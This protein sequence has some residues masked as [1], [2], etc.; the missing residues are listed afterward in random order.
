MAMRRQIEDSAKCKKTE[1]DKYRMKHLYS[2][3]VRIL[4]M[5]DGC[6]AFE[7]KDLLNKIEQLKERHVEEQIDLDSDPDFIYYGTLIKLF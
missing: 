7:L 6:T 3:Q 5:E 4:E 1:K 2:S